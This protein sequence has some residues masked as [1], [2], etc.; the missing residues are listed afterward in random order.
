MSDWGII[1]DTHPM[2]F[3]SSLR[4]LISGHFQKVYFL[5]L[6][7]GLNFASFRVVLAKK[8]VG[9]IPAR[10]AAAKNTRSAVWGRKV[11]TILG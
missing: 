5:V 2:S 1:T 10:V 6:V 3:S 7:I 4:S 11:S 9:T 8:W